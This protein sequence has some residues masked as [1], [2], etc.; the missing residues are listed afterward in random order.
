[1]GGRRMR[2]VLMMEEQSFCHWIKH[3]DRHAYITYTLLDR[4]GMSLNE[5]AI[6]HRTIIRTIG[7]ILIQLTAP[8]KL[9]EM[10]LDDILVHLIDAGFSRWRT[11]EGHY[12]FTP[13]DQEHLTAALM[14]VAQLYTES[15]L[16]S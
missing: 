4:H 6:E 14:N 8:S 9:P 2:D 10:L 5:D 11:A 12:E 7:I 3:T 16:S 1:M 13:I 15:I